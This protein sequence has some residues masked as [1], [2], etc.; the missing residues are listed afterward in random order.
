MFV[1]MLKYRSDKLD[2]DEMARDYIRQHK[3]D[4]VKSK[5][6]RMTISKPKTVVAFVGAASKE[7]FSRR[8]RKNTF[9]GKSSQK[10][11][12]KFGF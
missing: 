7:Y 10:S 5:R 8:P 4:V 2:H 1:R 11:H 6:K 12:Y 3:K 9:K